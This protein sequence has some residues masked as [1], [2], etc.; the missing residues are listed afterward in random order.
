M[1]LSLQTVPASFK[2][3]GTDRAHFC[4][5]VLGILDH[6]SPFSYQLSP[7]GPSSVQAWPDCIVSVGHPI[8]VT[9]Q[10]TA[11]EDKANGVKKK[12][13]NLIQVSWAYEENKQQ[14]FGCPVSVSDTKA[15]VGRQCDPWGTELLLS[16]ITECSTAASPA[17]TNRHIKKG[18]WKHPPCWGHLVGSQDRDWEEFELAQCWQQVSKAEICR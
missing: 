8:T 9:E 14:Q 7:W 5:S 1:I 13:R 11:Q 15:I 3:S 6:L 2:H 12:E 4:V 18:V 16:G 17:A 10:L